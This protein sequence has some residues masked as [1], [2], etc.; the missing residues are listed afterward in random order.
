VKVPSDLGPAFGVEVRV[1]VFRD[2]FPSS[3]LW[4]DFK[5]GAMLNLNSYQPK[6]EPDEVS[7]LY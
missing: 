2:P 6:G 3:S 5:G 1:E 7:I 4:Q